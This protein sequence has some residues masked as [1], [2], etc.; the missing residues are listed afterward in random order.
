ME[1]GGLWATGRL[2]SPSDRGVVF[3]PA[4]GSVSVVTC[5]RQLRGM[6]PQVR[7]DPGG[8]GVNLV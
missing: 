3:N 2:S 7:G 6:Q 5:L 4:L 8:L 1:D